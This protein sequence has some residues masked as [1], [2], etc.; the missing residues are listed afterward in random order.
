MNNLKYKG[1]LY[2]IAAVILATLCIQVYWNYKNYLIGKQQLI[3]EVQSSLDKAVDDYYTD[4]AKNET[5]NLWKDSISF[6]TASKISGF[7]GISDT[8]VFKEGHM[9][10]QLK[11]VPGNISVLRKI[12][13]DSG[14]L[15]ITIIDSSN[16]F[17]EQI[18][19]ASQKRLFQD[20]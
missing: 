15:N 14:D 1:I 19:Q 20:E 8:L 17:K 3:N 4:I 13:K 10:L 2:F 5:F 12:S 18:T 16:S 11:S 6:R 9:D 7:G